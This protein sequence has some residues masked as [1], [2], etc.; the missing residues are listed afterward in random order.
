MPWKRNKAQG[1][2]VKT[3]VSEFEGPGPIHERGNA[4]NKVCLA[5]KAG[6]GGGKIET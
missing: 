6:I 1:T 4:K 3:D 2:G 5:K